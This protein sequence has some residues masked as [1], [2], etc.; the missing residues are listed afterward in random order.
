MSLNNK[1]LALFTNEFKELLPL[2]IEKLYIPEKNILILTLY[3]SGF[4]KH[5]M[6]EVGSDYSA[7]YF[8]KERPIQNLV[9]NIQSRFRDLL[10]NGILKDICQI[11]NDRVLELIIENKKGEIFF[12]YSIIVNFF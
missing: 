3:K 12:I 10:L 2:K 4:K 6:I 5:L 9:A 7:L 8:V 1:E 11:N